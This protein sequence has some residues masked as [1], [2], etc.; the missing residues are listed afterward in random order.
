M[1]YNITI[2]KETIGKYWNHKKLNDDSEIKII[3]HDEYSD[4]SFEMLKDFLYN[5]IDP[6]ADL[7]PLTEEKVRNL[8]ENEF[9]GKMPEEY[10]KNIIKYN[11]TRLEMYN[12]IMTEI[13]NENF[14]YIS[15]PLTKEYD[16]LE[17]SNHDKYDLDEVYVNSYISIKKV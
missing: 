8:F 13:Q 3:H 10:T 11:N 2:H 7:V 15:Y 12:Q 16:R 1:K 17:L 9:C 4:L 5:E 14:K 6:P